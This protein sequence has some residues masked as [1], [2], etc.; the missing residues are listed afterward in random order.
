MKASEL[1]IGDWVKVLNYYWDGSPY[2]GQVD[3]IVKKHG[4][5][6]LQFVDA[7]SADIDRCEPIPLTPEILQKNGFELKEEDE[8]HTT[9]VSVWNGNAIISFAFFKETMYDV[10][11]VLQCE[12]G[13]DG[14][15]DRLHHC[16]TQYVHQLQHALRLCGFEKEIEL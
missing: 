15:L 14:G 2:I 10:D 16:H 4:T 5:Y 6:Y 12:F 11:T 1:S 9:Y 8:T 3:G 13:F 7:F